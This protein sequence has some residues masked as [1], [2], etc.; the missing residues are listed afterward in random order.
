[1]EKKEI[2]KLIVEIQHYEMDL[3]EVL[4]DDYPDYRIVKNKE[5]AIYNRLDK[6]TN[7]RV[8]KE[9]I[10]LVIQHEM[11]DTEDHTFKPIFNKLRELGVQV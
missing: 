7:D 8:L 9:K 6:I 10:R 4:D 11:W 2:Q 5:R 1:M 3:F